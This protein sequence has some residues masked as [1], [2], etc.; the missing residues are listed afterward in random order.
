MRNPIFDGFFDHM[1]QELAA[2]LLSG[3]I[4][5]IN[6]TFEQELVFQTEAPK[7]KSSCSL[8]IL[9]LDG[10]N[11]TP[12][13]LLKIL[14]F[15][16]PLLWLCKYLQGAVIELRRTT[17][18]RNCVSNKNEIEMPFPSA[19]WSKS[20]AS[21]VILFSWIA[22]AIKSSEAIKTC[23]FSQNI[24]NHS[25]GFDQWLLRNRRG[26]SFTLLRWILF[27]SSFTRKS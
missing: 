2:E 19:S 25:S 26:Q 1:V 22:P 12:D 10:F 18:S 14:P 16:I 7:T 5:K 9:S 11:E 24:I 23:R 13:Q 21:T 8:P 6:Q 27:A 20:W 4:Q 15:Q 3:C 17:D